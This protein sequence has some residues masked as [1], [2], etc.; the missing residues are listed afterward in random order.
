MACLI[1]KILLAT[2]RWQLQAAR[3]QSL[4]LMPKISSTGL[5]ILLNGLCALQVLP[6]VQG[7][8]ESSYNR[9]R[10]RH[11]VQVPT[12]RPYR[13]H[14]WLFDIVVFCSMPWELLLS[15]PQNQQIE[16]SWLFVP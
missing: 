6:N 9:D 8:Q 11:G 15:S 14:A 5:E 16:Q 2:T 13:L 3:S 12:R 1:G 10:T 4:L 7:E